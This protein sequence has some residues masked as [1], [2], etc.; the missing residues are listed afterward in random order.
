[1]NNQQLARILQRFADLLGIKGENPFRIN[2]YQRAAEVIDHLPEPV[3]DL[4]AN[5]E[6]TGIPGIGPG[7]AAALKEL[8]ETGHYGALDEL[9]NEVPATLLTL[10]D[11]PGLGPKTIGRLY[12]EL[13]ITSLSELE[14]AALA[15]RIRQLKGLGKRSEE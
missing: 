4:I 2:A 15:D 7:T 13:G 5:G 8:V 6:L 14:A 12:R 9:T 11:I 10:L 1:M 3:A